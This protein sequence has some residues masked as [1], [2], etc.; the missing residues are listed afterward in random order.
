MLA[1]VWV[2]ASTVAAWIGIEVYDNLTRIE[3]VDKCIIEVKIARP[4]AD[5][6]EIINAC[7]IIVR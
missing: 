6:K 2:A 4:D 3:R 7:E 1:L 5:L